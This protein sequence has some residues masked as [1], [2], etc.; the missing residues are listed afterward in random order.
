MWEPCVGLKIE[1]KKD[2]IGL[3]VVPDQAGPAGVILREQW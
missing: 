2:C 1:S 3:R